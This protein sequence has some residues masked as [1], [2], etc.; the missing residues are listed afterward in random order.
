[1]VVDYLSMSS[2]DFGARITGNWEVIPLAWLVLPVQAVDLL[3]NSAVS[4]SLIAPNRR[5]MLCG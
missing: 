4:R 2:V 5:S 1:M 3:L